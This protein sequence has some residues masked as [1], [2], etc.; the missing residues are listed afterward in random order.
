MNSIFNP[1]SKI[2][3][4]EDI[5][6]K[7]KLEEE[8]EEETGKENVDQ[9]QE[10]EEQN[11]FV[12]TQSLPSSSRPSRLWRA[13]LYDHIGGLT[14]TFLSLTPFF[15]SFAQDQGPSQSTQAELNVGPDGLAQALPR[16]NPVVGRFLLAPTP[17]NLPLPLQTELK[18][19]APP[20]AL[21]GFLPHP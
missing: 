10:K 3:S 16:A 13:S 6:D 8:E 4:L 18:D 7:V 9:E 19:E 1:I 20:S 2:S 17:W 12:E 5:W 21:H 11:R 15:L 14:L